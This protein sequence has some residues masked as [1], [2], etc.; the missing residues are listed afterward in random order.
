MKIIEVLISVVLIYA[1]LSMLVS[2][3]VEM[4]NNRQK[5][6]GKMLHSAILQML[7]D[8]LNLQY[9]YLL[10]KHPLINS[11]N[12]QQEK[13]PFQYLASDAFADAFIDVIGQQAE[14]GLPIQKNK[15][16]EEGNSF[17]AKGEISSDGAMG[18]FRIGMQQMNNSPFKDMLL[19]FYSKSD[20]DYTRLKGMIENWFDNF[21]DR[22]TGWYKRKQ[23]VKFRLVGLVVAIFL[24]VDSI[25]LFK[26]ISMDD[27]L[28]SSLT[29][30]AEGMANE[31]SPD[32]KDEQTL[33]LHQLTVLDSNIQKLH[34]NAADTVRSETISKILKG[35]KTLSDNISKS[36]SLQQ[37][38]LEQIKQVLVLSDQLGFPIGW[39]KSEAPLSW[40]NSDESPK[41]PTN[42]LGIY[43]YHR[44]E[45]PQFWTVFLYVIG[46]LLTGFLLSFGAPFWFDI[47]IKFV[48]IRKAGQKPQAT[49]TSQKPSS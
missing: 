33:L 30:V 10:L 48:N 7:D 2:S 18:L 40:F 24:N 15:D 44:N 3:I 41:M 5:S 21:M 6:R 45:Q 14:T 19:S 36:D 34:T 4:L 22:T 8:P 42:K 29:Q 9:G 49:N 32:G 38:Q 47:L 43:L 20:G 13:R 17:T 37:K 23:I 1:L 35:T 46:I 31:Y 16:G 27:N 25:H 11:M 39:S 12:N 28:R 26:V